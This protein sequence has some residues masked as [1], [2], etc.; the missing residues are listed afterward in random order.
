[1]KKAGWKVPD[2]NGR[3]VQAPQAAANQRNT[4][5]KIHRK[6]VPVEL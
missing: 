1:M 5:E 6:S 4:I 2:A 3:H